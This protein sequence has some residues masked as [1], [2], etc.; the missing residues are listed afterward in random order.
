MKNTWA[1]INHL[2][3]SRRKNSKR[4]TSIR[5]LD[6]SNLTHNPLEIPNIFNK[7]FSSVGHKLA[8]KLP[9]CNRH[10][11]EFLNQNHENSLFFYSV[12]PTEIERDTFNSS[13]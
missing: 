13:Q 6:N 12:T 2:I 11:T 7:Y 8:S 4:I 10:F 3:N 9:P 1:G 5:Y